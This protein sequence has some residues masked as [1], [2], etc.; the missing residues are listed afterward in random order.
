MTFKSSEFADKIYLID[1]TRQITYAE[2]FDK[3]QK[4]IDKLQHIPQGKYVV[5]LGAVSIEAYQLYFA[6][7]AVQAIWAPISYKLDP[8]ILIPILNKLNPALIIYDN[9]ANNVVET[10]SSKIWPCLK[11]TEI[12]TDFSDQNETKITEAKQSDRI[13]S[14]YLT[15]GSTGFPKVVLHSWEATQQH[16]DATVKRYQFTA[17]SRLFNPRQLFHVSG[18]FPLTTFMHCGGSIVIPHP[19]SLK[20]TSELCQTDWAQLMLQSGVTHASFLPTEMQMYADLIDKH[21]EF[22]PAKLQRITTGGEAVELSELIKILRAFAANR[23]CY[24]YLWML[25]PYLEDGKLFTLFKMFYELIYGRLVQVTQT[26]GA[27]ELICNAIANTSISGPDTRGIGSAVQSV[28]PEI[29]DEQGTILPQ[30]GKEIGRLRFFGS[31]IASG[32]LDNEEKT[33][34]S[35]YYQT[36]D[37]ASIASNGQVTFFGRSENLIQLSGEKYKINPVILE[38]E[39]KKITGVHGVMVFE[40]SQRLHAA[41]KVRV[42]A[43]QAKIISTLKN[44]KACILITTISLW[45]TFPLTLGGKIDRKSLTD[46]VKGEE[47]PVLDLGK[48]K[49]AAGNAK[50]KFCLIV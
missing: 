19:S 29:V 21:P 31:S 37:L 34:T 30:N 4:V 16:A 1:S 33:L 36:N 12:F 35:Y 44:N 7:I 46:K 43:D 26:Y 25:Y 18:A 48:W 40:Y 20:K 13:I 24:D 3:I 17:E 49:P 5:F 41:I 2:N 42:G 6:V 27:T 8:N 11:L 22:K 15:S 23:A 38:R 39:I 9:E 14:A 45:D 10:L 47:K 50:Y 28:H 32:Y